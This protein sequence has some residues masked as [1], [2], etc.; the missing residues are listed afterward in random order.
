MTKFENGDI[1][2]KVEEQINQVEQELKNLGHWREAQPNPKLFENMGAFGSNTMPF[3]MWLQFVFIPNVKKII[4]EQGT[5]PK[6]SQVATY[7]YRN[8]EGNEYDRLNAL[9]SE[10][11]ALFN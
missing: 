3:T 7:A 2:Q 1:Y 10:F 4:T 8:L 5:F 6:S 9:L 11:D